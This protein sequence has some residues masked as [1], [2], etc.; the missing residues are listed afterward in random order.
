MFLPL[1]LQVFPYLIVSHL[2]VHKFSIMRCWFCNLYTLR[3]WAND[4]TIYIIY[5]PFD[6][7]ISWANHWIP[8]TKKFRTKTTPTINLVD[9]AGCLFGVY[10][11]CNRLQSTEYNHRAKIRRKW[12]CI[13]RAAT[14]SVRYVKKGKEISKIK[15]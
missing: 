8:R 7:S 15:N 11:F 2:S 12:R 4:S 5:R 9:S 6:W 1:L 14:P 10:N 3:N 13:Q